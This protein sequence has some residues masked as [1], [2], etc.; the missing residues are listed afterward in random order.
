M[1]VLTLLFAMTLALAS[2]AFAV[3]QCASEADQ[4]AFEVMSLR[5]LMTVYVTKCD[6][7]DEYNNYFIKRFQPVL[8][9]NDRQVLAYFRRLYGGRGQGQMDTFTTEL[10]NVMSQVANTQAGEYCSRTAYVIR[11]MLALKAQTDLAAYAA[12][13][14]IAPPGTSMCPASSA[15]SA[16]KRR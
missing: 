2:P 14:D 12:T 6:R 11:E 8:Q 5:E 10:V 9:D 15:A 7:G 1:R 16:K 13:K 3:Q 4:S